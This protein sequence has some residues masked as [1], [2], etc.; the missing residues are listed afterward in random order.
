MTV[1]TVTADG[2]PELTIH[3][4]SAPA[5]LMEIIAERVRQLTEDL[6]N[7]VRDV[8]LDGGA[9]NRVTGRLAASI[10]SGFVQEASSATG[11]VSS[12]GVEYAGVHELGGRGFYDIVPNKAEALSFIWQGEK[13]FFDRV[14]HPPAQAK[15]FLGGSLE[16]YAPLIVAEIRGAVEAALKE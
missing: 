9:L 12:E 16:T 3:F 1:L 8:A 6:A 2:L 4:E 15:R 7:Y 13:V 5:D 11:T 14:T 10:H